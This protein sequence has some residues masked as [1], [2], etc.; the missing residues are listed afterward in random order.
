[1]ALD[2][3]EEHMHLENLLLEISDGV[4]LQGGVVRLQFFHG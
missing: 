3:Q 2:S 4:R 1:M